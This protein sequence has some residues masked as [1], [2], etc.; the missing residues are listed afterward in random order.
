MFGLSLNE[1]TTILINSGLTPTELF[2]VRLL[3]IAIEGDSKPL[4]NYISNIS[5]GK[6]LIR[7]VLESLKNKKVINST[8]DIPKEGESLNFKNIP[9]NKNFNKAI[10]RD[11]HE[12]GKELFDSYPPF[13]TIGGR[14]CSIKNFTKAGLY[15]LE[16]FCSYYAKTI[17]NCGVTHERVMQALLFAKENSLIS[18]SILEFISSMKWLEIEHI[19]NSGNIN[20]YNNTELL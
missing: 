8:F 17:K 13:I 1:E 16:D 10:I 15:S 5:D 7:K 9:F 12:L 18:Y 6:I 4:I 3:L 2:I 20:G 11:S 14:L 19:Q